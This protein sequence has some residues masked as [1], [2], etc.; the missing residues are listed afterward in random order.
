MDCKD[1]KKWHP[2]RHVT[3]YELDESTNEYKCT[4]IGKYYDGEE[5]KPIAENE[6]QEIKIYDGLCD[7]SDNYIFDHWD[8]VTVSSDFGCKFFEQNDK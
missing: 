1:C 6:K 5:I 8:G 4:A 2:I 3:I 7:I